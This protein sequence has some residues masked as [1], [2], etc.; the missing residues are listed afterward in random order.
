M[1]SRKVEPIKMRNYGRI[2]Q[3]MIRVAQTEPERAARERLTV[4]IA[5]CMRQRNMVWNKDQEI[6]AQRI[7]DD[8]RTLSNGGLSTDFPGFDEAIQQRKA[9]FNV[10][11]DRKNHEAKP[12]QKPAQQQPSQQQPVA[13][14]AQPEKPAAQQP[15]QEKPAAEKPA[16]APAPKKRGRPSGRKNARHE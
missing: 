12:A 2:I 5:Q 10:R 6:G 16:V 8:I 3:D 14:P 15:A 4:Y 11:P 7:K 9:D 1:I 13:K